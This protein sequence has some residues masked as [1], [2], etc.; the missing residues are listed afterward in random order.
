M[1]M[2]KEFDTYSDKTQA[3]I[4]RAIASGAGSQNASDTSP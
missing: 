2:T 3:L 1:F 4:K